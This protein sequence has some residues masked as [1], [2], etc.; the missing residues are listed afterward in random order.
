MN[1][2]GK[3]LQ[4]RRKD[5]RLNMLYK[6]IND[7]ANVTNKEILIPQIS[8]LECLPKLLVDSETIDSFKHDLK[9]LNSPP[10]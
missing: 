7:I 3:N 4:D 5:I 10:K 6:I 2:A 8:E 9:Y 1:L